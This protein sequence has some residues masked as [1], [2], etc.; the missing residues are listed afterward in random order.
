MP[1]SILV[2]A[3]VA[4]RRGAEL[5]AIAPEHDLLVL[6]DG[7]SDADLAGV[8]IVFWSMDMFPAMGVPLINAVRRAPNVRWLHT[9]S[10]GTDHPV[11]QSFL[12][13]GIELTTSSGAAAKPIA[14]TVML[15]VLAHGR[16]LLE[17]LDHQRSRRWEQGQNRDIEGARMLVVG[18]GPIGVE[19][20]KLAQAFG[21]EVRPCGA[22]RHRTTPARPPGSTRSRPPSATPTTSSRPSRST[23]TPRGSSAR[24]SSRP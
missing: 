16:R 9:M 6:R 19:T 15:Y 18:M 21:M 2:S 7:L 1:P 10:A 20:V 3:H 17:R 11:F 4:A 22:P 12:D 5:C 24:R 14:H 23:T 8:D 13:R